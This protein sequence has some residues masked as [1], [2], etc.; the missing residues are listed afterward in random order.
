M[1]HLTHIQ[2][3]AYL[4]GAGTARDAVEQ[5]LAG[6]ERCR[7]TL[8]EYRAVY[9]GLSDDAGFELPADFAARVASLAVAKAAPGPS[10]WTAWAY[11]AA[12]VMAAAMMYIFVDLSP[13]IGT[14]ETL[15][16][17]F[18]LGSAIGQTVA[19]L[20]NGLGINSP[21]LPAAILVLLL[22]GAVD[23]IVA[24]ARRGKTM[25]LT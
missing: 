17:K 16:G 7:A 22:Y 14:A 25:L 5:H 21:L 12:A 10:Q 3:Q 6:C 24:A 1:D 19:N 15:V 11:A 9:R 18:A 4:D 13:I 20:L 2:I 23:R 8:E